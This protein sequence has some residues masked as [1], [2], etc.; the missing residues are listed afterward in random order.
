MSDHGSQ[1]LEP[2]TPPSNQPSD[3]TLLSRLCEAVPDLASLLAGLALASTVVPDGM[4]SVGGGHWM[5]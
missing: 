5:N 1:T 3:E 2:E 4:G